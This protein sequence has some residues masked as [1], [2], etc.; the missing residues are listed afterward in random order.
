MTIE[1][2]KEILKGNFENPDDKIYWQNKLAELERKAEN[3]REN[4]KFYKKNAKYNR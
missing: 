4:E 3:A 1:Q 2:V